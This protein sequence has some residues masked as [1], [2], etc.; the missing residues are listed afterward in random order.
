MASL[1]VVPVVLSVIVVNQEQVSAPLH[2]TKSTE[3]I[4]IPEPAK[5]LKDAVQHGCQRLV[6]VLNDAD[7]V[8]RLLHFTHTLVRDNLKTSRSSLG[9][10]RRENAF[11]YIASG[12]ASRPCSG[13]GSYIHWKQ[14]Y[15]QNWHQVCSDAMQSHCLSDSI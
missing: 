13:E 15:Q 10:V 2:N 6:V 9:Q 4:V 8:M 5:L 7:T 3:P 11:P 1:S 14:C 12:Q